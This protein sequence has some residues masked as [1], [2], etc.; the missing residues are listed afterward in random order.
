MCRMG[1][2]H[3][4]RFH[5]MGGEWS[6]PPP[7]VWWRWLRTKHHNIEHT[8]SRS[9]RTTLIH[10]IPLFGNQTSC[11]LTCLHLWGAHTLSTSAL[12][13]TPIC[14]IHHTPH[15]TVVQPQ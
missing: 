13:I 10:P 15:H 2:G 9:T 12:Y 11:L 6:I 4:R 7:P 3:T 1:M 5:R 8:T 14:H